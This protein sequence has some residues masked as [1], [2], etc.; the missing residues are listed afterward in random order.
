MGREA[1]G[2]AVWRGAAGAVR[3][4]L[5]RDGITLRGE[6]R[7]KLPRAS[8]MHWRAEGDD[9]C[10]TAEGGALVLTLGAKEATAWV[11]ALEKPLPSLAARL[12]VADTAKAWVMAGLHRKNWP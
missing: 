11:R 6:V 4:Y 9:L 10:L 7:A 1:D 3:A 2:H 8:L 5:E 12:G